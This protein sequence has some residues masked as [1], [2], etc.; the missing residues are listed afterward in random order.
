MVNNSSPSPLEHVQIKRANFHIQA[1]R[2]GCARSRDQ[3]TSNEDIGRKQETNIKLIMKF[4]RNDQRSSKQT[5]VSEDQHKLLGTRFHEARSL[6]KFQNICF[7]LAYNC[8][9]KAASDA[10]GD[11]Q[12]FGPGVRKNV[13]HGSE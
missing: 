13:L 5:N 7:Y 9:R 6:S 10:A 3:F 1:L 4:N 8:N 11:I 2:T 12:P